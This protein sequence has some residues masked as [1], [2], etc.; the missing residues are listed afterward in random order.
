MD[1]VFQLVEQLLRS[2]DAEGWNE[3]RAVVGQGMFD[4]LLQAL[5]SGAAIFM[6]AVTVGTFQYQD[7]GTAWRYAG[8]ENRCAGRAE[9]AGEHDALAG[10]T[11]AVLQVHFDIGGA[12]HMGGAL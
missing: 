4:N 6:Q 1:D 8:L 11:R 5:T 12:K 2:A 9:V 7:V 3:H 10:F